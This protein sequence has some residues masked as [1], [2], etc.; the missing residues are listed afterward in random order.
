MNAR[1]AL[2]RRRELVAALLNAAAVWLPARNRCWFAATIVAV[3]RESDLTIDRREVAALDAVLK[4]CA[5]R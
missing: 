3:R 1:R 4:G 5:D 2:T